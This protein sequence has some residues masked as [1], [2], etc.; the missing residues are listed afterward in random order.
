MNFFKD[1]EVLLEDLDSLDKR[2]RV[3]WN[4]KLFTVS[5]TY[6]SLDYDR[7]KIQI[8]KKLRMIP[9]HIEDDDVDEN[10]YANKYNNNEIVIYYDNVSL[11]PKLH[12]NVCFI[13]YKEKPI[14]RCKTMYNI[15]ISLLCQN[16]LS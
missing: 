1:I 5:Y 7:S 14:K 4:K 6:S 10:I 13:D 3:K 12:K 8:D 2:K 9:K 15:N 11:N 16:N